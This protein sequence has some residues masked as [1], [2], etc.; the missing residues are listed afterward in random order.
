MIRS[1]PT[2]AIQTSGQKPTGGNAS[3]ISSAEAIPGIH[4]EPRVFDK[5]LVGQLTSDEVT[6][7]RFELAKDRPADS[8]A[9][10]WRASPVCPSE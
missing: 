8:S 10:R 1:Q 7:F 3:Q 5:A 4:T 9:T 2:G 6:G